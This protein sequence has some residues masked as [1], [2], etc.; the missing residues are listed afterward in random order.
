[1][2]L[3]PAQTQLD[4]ADQHRER[5]RDRPS[6]DQLHQ[7]VLTATD[8]VRR[9]LIQVAKP[10]AR[11]RIEGVL[12]EVGAEIERQGDESAREYSMA[13]RLV[14]R[15]G[16]DPAL[17]RSML[18]EVAKQ[19]EFEAAVVLLAA[20]ASLPIAAVERVV[21]SGEVGGILLLCKAIDLKWPSVL[22]VLSV[23]RTASRAGAVQLDGMS[24]QF[25]KID[26]STARRVVRFWQVRSTSLVSPTG[27]DSS[28]RTL[29]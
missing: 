19:N 28:G 3:H 11:A 18:V 23:H 24:Q 1:M 29:Q 12:R 17:L 7:L 22:A 14:E 8:V 21:N 6:A 16:P 13:K 26:A 4:P 27:Q 9:K 5:S 2:C 10:E 15:I 20:L 25:A